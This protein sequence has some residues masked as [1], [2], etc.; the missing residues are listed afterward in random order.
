MCN[1]KLMIEEAI[2]NGIMPGANYCVMTKDSKE[3]GSCGLKAIFPEKEENDIDTLYDMASVT[4]VV[5]TTTALFLLMEQ[6]KLRLY[7]QVKT[8]LPEFR[9][10]GTTIWDLATHT[11]GLPSN[12]ITKLYPD[13][14]RLF[15]L[16]MN[17][18]LTYEPHTK[19]V[20]SDLGFITLG[21]VIERVSGIPLDVFVK[22][23][24]LDPLEMFDSGFC[25]TDVKRCAPTEDRGNCIDRGYVHDEKAHKMDGVAG[26]AGLFA[27]IND[28][29]HFMEMM[30]NEGVYKGKRFLSKQS[31]D[32]MYTV[33]VEEVDGVSRAINRRSIG[34]LLK[35]D[36]PSSGDLVS[37]DTIMH[38][39][40][41]GT[42]IF[43]D[44]KNKVAFCMLANR[45]HPSRDNIDIIA[46]RA[47]LGNYIM[48]HF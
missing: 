23:N 44:R 30:L 41:T 7:D 35:G 6:G 32:M 14:E 38:T 36:Y 29:S 45:V 48:S 25:P 31:I 42:N 47:K 46:F 18:E 1:I 28:M 12:V 15:E 39:G 24:I 21:H 8:Y 22:E 4:K 5:A 43:I 2:A 20:Y 34:W 13:K 11:S 37:N 27:T 16:V 26:H 10:R 3:M 9:H 17:S 19:I 33:Q 40:F